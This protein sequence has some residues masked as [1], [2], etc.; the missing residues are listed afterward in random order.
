VLAN[1]HVLDW[2]HAGL[3]Q[4]L[5]CLHAAGLRTTGAGEDAAAAAA[6]AVIELPTGNRLLVFAWGMDSSGVISSWAARADR[7]GVNFLRDFSSSSLHAVAQRIAESRRED[8]VTVASIHWGGNWGYDVDRAQRDF[9]H[10]LIDQAGVD[11]VHGHSSHHPMG[12]EVHHGKL[13]LHG[14]GDLINDYEGIGGYEEFN[15]DLALLYFP[16]LEAG[17]GRLRQLAMTAVQRR[18][19]RLERAGASRTRWLA[20]MLTRE[21]R[22]LGTSVE[23]HGEDRLT[24]RW[25]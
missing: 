24:L 25:D 23:T 14:C 11:I 12:V 8:D 15:P 19:F 9:A 18:R 21:G 7:A 4:T 20:E 10:R 1:N 16:T 3:L 22:K 13:V 17:T 5:S 6:P 2:G